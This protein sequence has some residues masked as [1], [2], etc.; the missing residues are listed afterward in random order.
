MTAAQTYDIIGA[1]YVRRRQT[2]PNWMAAIDTALGDARTV[3]NIGA[4]TGS[5]EPL[6][7]LVM[8]IEPSIEMIRQRA[9]DA[10]P[11]ICAGAERLP[12]ADDEY[13]AAMAVQT[14]HHWAD[15]RRGLAEMRRVSRRQ[16]VVCYDT[17][18][19][20]DFWLARDYI[21]EIAELEL[22][23]P[24]AHDIAA[25]LG[26]DSMIP[27]LVPWDFTDGVYPA[28]WRRPEMY[29]DPVVRET[30]SALAQSPPDAVTRG[31]D[32]LRADLQSGHWH[33]RNRE[34]LQRNEFDAG[35][36]LVVAGN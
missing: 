34:L 13:D 36:R 30:C 29:L 10:A 12:V 15:W 35:F 22:A 33:W 23:R 28:Y 19:H 14:V 26:T 31:M 25:E 11:V 3:L 32:R 24:S 16:V 27:L 18:L 8:A 1:G 5:Y 6:D 20:A 2:D 21:P 4:G 17:R 7:R 9:A